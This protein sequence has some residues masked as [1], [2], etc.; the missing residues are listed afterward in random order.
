[1]GEPQPPEP[2]AKPRK[3]SSMLPFIIAGL[4]SGSV[5]GLIGIGLVLTYRTSGVFNFAYG[6]MGTVAAYVFYFL[7]VEHGVSVAIAIVICLVVVAPLMG[8]IMERLTA[9]LAGVGL[10]LQIAA[11]VGVLLVV[12]ALAFL[13]YGPNSLTI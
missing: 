4:V 6:A 12:E 5:Y 3:I 13:I 10:A 7:H 11:T 9:G 2:L 1:M 8:L